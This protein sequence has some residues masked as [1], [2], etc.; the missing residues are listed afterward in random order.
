MH[1]QVQ[2][3]WRVILP[4]IKFGV[5]MAALLAFVLSSAEIG[6]TL[7]VTSVNAI[8]RPR[9]MWTGVHDNIDPEIAAVSVLLI[10]ATT[11]GLLGRMMLQWAAR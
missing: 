11:I 8:T 10:A 2:R 5:L 9:L 6:V 1:C 4:N 7:L 3:A